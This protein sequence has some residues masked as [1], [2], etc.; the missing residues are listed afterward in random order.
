[1][2]GLTA[3]M[4]TLLDDRELRCSAGRTAQTRAGALSW[5]AAAASTLGALLEAAA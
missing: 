5:R 3:A 1:V 2:E 4:R